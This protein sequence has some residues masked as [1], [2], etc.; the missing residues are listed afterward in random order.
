[1]GTCG[2]CVVDTRMSDFWDVSQCFSFFR[3]G[4]IE[5][6]EPI[7]CIDEIQE[8]RWTAKCCICDTRQGACI[9]C[10]VSTCKTFFHVTCA[11]RSGLEM[12]IEQDTDDDKV[13]MISLCSK[14]RS[15]KNFEPDEAIRDLSQVTGSDE[16][17]EVQPSS[18]PLA[19]LEQ[20]CYVFVDYKDVA[21]RLSLDLLFVSDVFEYWKWRRLRNNG[22]PLIDNLQ[23]EITID[24]PEPIQ[25]ELPDYTEIS[26]YETEGKAKKKRGRPKKDAEGD[27]VATPSSSAYGAKK[28]TKTVRSWVRLCNSLHKGH[29]LL[30]LVLRKAK[31]DRNMV[32]TCGD[33]AILIAEHISR[34]VPISQRTFA[35]LNDSVERLYSKEVLQEGEAK[36]EEPGFFTESPARTPPALPDVKEDEDELGKPRLLRS[37]S[38]LPSMFQPSRSPEKKTLSLSK[39]GMFAF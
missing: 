23:D 36:A 27:G 32:H 13:H 29:G 10:S 34:P 1:M 35:Y 16:E 19:S 7:M 20:T 33:A 37:R 25:L 26:G 38:S 24:E 31:E 28:M 2:L 9:K 17:T 14:H 18:G 3:F 22:R 12:R 5:K 21:K 39:S 15:A 6:R 11:L 30:G 4:D 8:E